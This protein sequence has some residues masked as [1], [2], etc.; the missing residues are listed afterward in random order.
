MKAE[1]ARHG[2]TVRPTTSGFAGR[3]CLSC[4]AVLRTID[5]LVTCTACGETIDDGRSQELGWTY[6]WSTSA[7]DLQPF[8]AEC[9]AVEFGHVAGRS[10]GR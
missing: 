7:G 5:R 4:A 1:M 6:W 9:A 3:Y 2:W 8:C 10:P